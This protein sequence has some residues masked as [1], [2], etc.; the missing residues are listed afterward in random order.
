MH[1]HTRCV[2]CGVWLGLLW[3]WCGTVESSGETRPG[4][5]HGWIT[6]PLIG[7]PLNICEITAAE[8]ANWSFTH[9]SPIKCCYQLTKWSRL[10]VKQIIS[11]RVTAKRGIHPSIHAYELAPP[12]FGF[13]DLELVSTVRSVWFPHEL[14]PPS[15]ASVSPLRAFNEFIWMLD[16]LCTKIFTSMLCL[17]EL[18]PNEGV[19]GDLRAP[20][21]CLRLCASLH[22]LYAE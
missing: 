22:S 12:F 1:T 7:G 20:L 5:A 18:S 17:A 21:V 4:Q 6:A 11:L 13:H 14:S 16:K 3:F 9:Q 8:P 19:P 10:Q 15:L 2:L